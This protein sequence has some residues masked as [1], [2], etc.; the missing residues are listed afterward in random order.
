M[1]KIKF[2]GIYPAM[3]VPFKPSGELDLEGIKKLVEFFMSAGCSGIL[4]N[5]STGEA[6]SLTRDERKDV[7]RVT[8]EAM[9]GH[10]KVIA[11]TG[12]P[13]TRET[14]VL[15]KDAM[16]AGADAAL[17]I[18]P[19]FIR[20][21]KKGLYLHYAEVAKVGIPVL[22]YNLP[23]PTR[24]EVDAD[25]LEK[26]IELDNIVGLKDSSGNMSYLSEIYRRFGD[27]IS[28]LSGADDLTL[29]VFAMGV[30]GA[31]LGLANIA[32]AQI[33]ELQKLVKAD[34]MAEARELY[35]KLLPIANCIN[36][37]FN[38][39]TQIKEAVRQLGRPSS[40]PRLPLLP[41]EPEEVDAIR[42]ALIHAGL[43]A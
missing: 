7:I 41:A 1:K 36:V 32:P 38:F 29:Q 16:D 20:P 40:P 8:V 3:V 10:G 43:L 25:T 18:T 2:E 31:I 5:G 4:C 9:K 21:T 34:K 15:T 23:P 26:L 11:G 33:V 39:P 13:T 12:A 30:K 24:Q 35:F 19:Y 42:K 27:K 14:L 28:I 6:A 22:C 37:S 17:V